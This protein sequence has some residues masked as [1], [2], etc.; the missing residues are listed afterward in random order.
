MMHY[1]DPYFAPRID[2]NPA[3]HTWSLGVEEQFDRAHPLVFF[4]WLK[5]RARSNTGRHIAEPLLPMLTLAALPTAASHGPRAI[6]GRVLLAAGAVSGSSARVRYCFSCTR[7]VHPLHARGARSCGFLSPSSQMVSLVFSRGTVYLCLVHL[8]RK[9]A[10]LVSSYGAVMAG[11][12]RSVRVLSHAL[13]V[14]LGT[15]S[16]SLYLWHWP[17]YVLL[18]WTTDLPTAAIRGPARAAHCSAF[19]SSRPLGRDAIR[20]GLRRAPSLAVIAA[21]LGCVSRPL[22]RAPM[23]SLS[24]GSASP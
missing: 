20:R 21:A 9:L 23:P 18:R 8:L 10:R 6:C 12:G 1:G 7:T 16:Y 14:W 17:V 3:A 24:T 22:G 19:G 11:N 2:Y 4:V 15:R 5:L 13:P